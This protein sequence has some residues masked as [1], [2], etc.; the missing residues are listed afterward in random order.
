MIKSKKY[1][2]IIKATWQRALTYRTTVI[3]YRIGEMLEIFFLI[4][5]WSA[6]YSNQDQLKGYNLREMLTY[7]LFGALISVIVRNWMS[8]VVARDIKDGTLSQFLVKPISYLRYMMFRE[9]GRISLAFLM[10]VATQVAMI[11]A[12]ADRFIFN[13]SPEYLLI[14]MVMVGLA[15][16]TEMFLSFLT[17][18]IAFWTNEVDGIYATLDRLKRFFAGGYFPINLLPIM[19]VKISFIL[20]FGYSFFVPAQ[21]YLKK[22]DPITGLK[23]ILVQ[24]VWVVLLYFIIKLIWKRGLRRYEGVG[25]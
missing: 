8:D 18:M 14:I 19:Y 15:F 10:S 24:I 21:L 13:T 5:L 3:S 12:F 16:I 1:I 9:I 2:A 6:I 25:I 7:I 23:G 11:M 17:G 22:I 20:P 4:L